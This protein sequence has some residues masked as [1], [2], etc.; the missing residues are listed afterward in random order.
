MPEQRLREWAT[1]GGPDDVRR[2]IE[3]FRDVGIDY[4]IGNFEAKHELEATA[5]FADEVVRKL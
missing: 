3:A 5:L 4:F 2:Q 1:F